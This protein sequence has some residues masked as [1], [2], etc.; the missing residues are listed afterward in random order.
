MKRKL[1]VLAVVLL[2]LL[3][4]ASVAFAAGGEEKLSL[5]HI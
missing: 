4:A 3:F 1:T 2:A 5:I